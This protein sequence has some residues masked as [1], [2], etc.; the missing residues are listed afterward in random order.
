MFGVDVSL[1]IHADDLRLSLSGVRSYRFAAHRWPAAGGVRASPTRVHCVL[2]SIPDDAERFEAIDASPLDVRARVRR[3]RRTWLKSGFG[4]RPDRPET[5][6][7]KAAAIHRLADDEVAAQVA[8]DVPGHPE[9]AA[10]VVA[11]RPA[12][13]QQGAQSLD[14]AGSPGPG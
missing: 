5:P 4:Q 12:H 10:K 7:R 3:R 1:Q 13:G 14:P 2:A 9:V 8:T 6:A 11:H